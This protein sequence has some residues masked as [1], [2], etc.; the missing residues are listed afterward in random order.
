MPNPQGMPYVLGLDVGANSI[1]WALVGLTEGVPDRLVA[2]GARVFDAGV[3]GNIQAGQAESRGTKRRQA[4]QQRR[5]A[6]RRGR[7]MQKVL[8]VLQHAGLLPAGEARSI[9][10]ELDAEL[11]TRYRRHPDAQHLSTDL[12]HVLPYWLRCRALD[13]P[14]EPFELGRA[15]YHLAQRRGFLSNRRAPKKKDEDE[16]QVLGGISALQRQMDAA[17]ARTLGELFANI[18]P[19]QE[20]IRN[21]YTSRRMCRDEFEQIWTA[22]QGFHP[23]LLPEKLK[24]RVREA[25]FYQRPLKDASLFIGG[26]KLEPGRKRAP[27]A[28]LAAQRF[29]L[30]Q[31]VNNTGVITKEGT[32]RALAEAERDALLEDLEQTDKI[33]FPQARRRLKLPRSSVFNWESGGEKRFIGNKTNAALSAIFGERWWGFSAQEREQVVEDVRSFEQ[34][35]ALARRGVS[36]WGLT[37]EQ[38]ADLAAVRL[39]DG[40]CRHSRQALARLLPHMESGLSYMEAVR[41]EYPEHGKP[42]RPHEMLPPLLDTDLDVRNPAVVRALTELRKIVNAIVRRYGKPHCIRI[43][44]ARDL[45]RSAKQRERSWKQA[46]RNERARSD[47]AD[48]LLAEAGIDQPSRRDV[49]KVLLADECDWTCPY[50]GQSF[51]WADLFGKAP[52]FDVEHIIPLSRRLNDSFI[53]KTICEVRENRQVKGNRTPWE[54]YGHDAERWSQIVERVKKF[55]STARKAKLALF[56]LQQVEDI[57]ELASRQLNDTRFS[58][59]LAAQYVAL[60]YGGLVDAQGTR[61]VQASRGGVTAFLRRLWGLNS[62]LGDAWQKSRADHRHHAVDALVVALTDPGAVKSLSDAAARGWQMSRRSF[63]AVQPP[64]QG[65]LDEARATVLDVNVSHRASRRVR[66]ALHEE[67]FYAPQKEGENGP[68]Y[69]HLRRKLADLSHKEVDAIVD[70]HVRELVKAKLDEIRLPPS[71]AFKDPQNHPCITARDGRSIPIHKARIRLNVSAV[72]VGHAE[73]LRWVKPGDN[74]HM[75]IVETTDRR[76]RPKWEGHLV[77][78][79]E[80]TGRLRAGE[81]VVRREHAPGKR[82]LFSLAGGE[83]IELDDPKLGRG[84]CVVRTVSAEKRGSVSVE[85]CRASDARPKNTIKDTGGWVKH[86]PDALRKAGARKVRVTLLGDVVPAND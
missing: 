21:R 29:R 19:R 38:A 14:L 6:D 20:R 61:R 63:A 86:S 10:P 52:A 1:G 73:P 30:L 84:I 48:R 54:A 44:L 24:A 46:R 4:R 31:M 32:E 79:L 72:P 11:I 51:G 39:E 82:F 67:T 28:L 77:T 26:C 35:D 76:G 49:E 3:Q 85:L 47:A 36:A 71:K 27:W 45:R 42:E 69:F 58:S 60:L 80:G 25:I 17:G 56:E 41:K 55:K 34:P 53:Y 81:P 50:T 40:Y 65:L 74:H 22:Q 37:P 64:W 78:R 83:L 70:P 16:G 2:A 66:G 62:I 33:T 9:L 5:L 18:D 59:R 13:H 57:E 8:H 23:T 43:E 75:E 15:L 7:R 12:T 68:A